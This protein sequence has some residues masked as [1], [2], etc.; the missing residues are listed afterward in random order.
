MDRRT[1]AQLCADLD[2]IHCVDPFERLPA[3]GTPGYFRLHGGPDYGH[4]FT[5]D[6]MRQIATWC[7]QYKV[8]WCVF[9]NK[10]MWDSSLRLQ[11]LLRVQAAA[12]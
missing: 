11:Q 1:R 6:E 10:D 7:R 12:P 2:L 9:N 4:M 5:D 3:H 8:G